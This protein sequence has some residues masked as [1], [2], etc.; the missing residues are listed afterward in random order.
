MKKAVDACSK[1]GIGLIAMKTQAKGH[2]YFADKIAP[3][4]KEQAIF[5]HFEKK[6]L[7]LEQAKL[8]A[9]WD[10]ERIAS[11][12]SGITN[13]AILQ[14]NVTAAVNNKRLSL[15]DRKFLDQYAH[16][17]ASFYCFGCSYICESG[18]EKEV[19]ISDIMRF[20]M[21]A[22]CY[23]ELENAKSNYSEIPSSVRKRMAHIDYKEA[24]KKCPQRIEIGRLMREATTELA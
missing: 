6:G 5:N 1:A 9:V 14:A 2:G 11:I 12:T 15:I 18:I 8:K 22:R 20:L 16:Q 10:D 17:T 7:T 13:M 19:P 24:E 23:G 3:N 4:K 21:Y